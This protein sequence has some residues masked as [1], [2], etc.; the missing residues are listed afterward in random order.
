MLLKCHQ[1]AYQ[2]KLFGET[3][4]CKRGA[5]QN[6]HVFSGV[7]FQA[8]LDSWSLVERMHAASDSVASNGMVC[9]CWGDKI[10]TER[11]I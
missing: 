9:L 2:W 11:V 7:K 5:T 3:L 1:R 10:A 8:L 4:L 6:K